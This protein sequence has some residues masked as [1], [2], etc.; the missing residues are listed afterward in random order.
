TEAPADRPPAAPGPATLT[1]RQGADGYDGA[2]GRQY[3]GEKGY[4]APDSPFLWV[5]W[6]D[7]KDSASIQHGSVSIL[8]FA[9]IIGPGARRIPLGSTIVRARLRLV[10][11]P[12]VNEWGNGARVFRL[13]RPIP[14]DDV[15]QTL[16]R[17]ADRGRS[18]ILDGPTVRA[19]GPPSWRRIESG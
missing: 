8:R 14:S 3:M 16:V 6:P 1:F 17:E 15:F 9:D 7:P 12:G 18:E 11:G 2:S 13:K 10:T 4:Q 19:G 5:D